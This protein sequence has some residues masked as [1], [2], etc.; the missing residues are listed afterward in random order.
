MPREG[1]DLSL[2]TL[3]HQVGACAIALQP[4]HD[5]IRTIFWQPNDFMG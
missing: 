3:A 4:I 5:L 1:V 2:S